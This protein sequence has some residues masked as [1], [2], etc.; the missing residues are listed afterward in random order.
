MFATD[1][2]SGENGI[3]RYRIQSQ[4]EGNSKIPVNNF[5]VDEK[6]GQITVI[7]RLFPGH[8]T[9]FVEGFDS[10]SSLSETRTSLAIVS[11]KLV[12]SGI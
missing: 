6:S 8:V 11:I 2:D 12:L 10:P 1:E 3:V 4:N 7:S 5:A 9:L